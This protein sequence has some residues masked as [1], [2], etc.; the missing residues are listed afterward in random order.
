MNCEH[1]MYS[2]KLAYSFRPLHFKKLKFTQGVL[3]C[4]LSA[5]FYYVLSAHTDKRKK[6]RI[7]LSISPSIIQTRLPDPDTIIIVTDTPFERRIDLE[8]QKRIELTFKIMCCSTVQYSSSTVRF[9]RIGLRVCGT[10]DVV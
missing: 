6:S 1:Q 7:P 9:V 3:R 2:Y 8:L 5:V 10:I 4:H